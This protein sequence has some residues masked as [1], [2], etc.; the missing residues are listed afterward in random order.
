MSGVREPTIRFCL[1]ASCNGPFGTCMNGFETCLCAKMGGIPRSL[2]AITRETSLRR[3][4]SLVAFPSTAG[5]R[6]L[7]R[8]MMVTRSGS[9]TAPRNVCLWRFLLL[10]L[11]PPFSADVAQWI[12]TIG[13]FLNRSRISAD[14]CLGESAVRRQLRKFGR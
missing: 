9:G 8:P 3:S 13:L 14:I 7:P 1:L 6:H 5:K 12:K 4:P 11:K 2:T 10:S